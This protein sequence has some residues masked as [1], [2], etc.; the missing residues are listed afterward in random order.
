MEFEPRVL[1]AEPVTS[2]QS[3]G[4]A[5]GRRGLQAAL[6]GGPGPTIDAVAASGL[7]GRG[8]AGFP[9]ATKWRTVAANLSEELPASVVVNAAEGEP[10]SFKDRAILLANPYRVLEGALIAA[11]TI[12]ADEVVI[13]TKSRWTE[14][15]DRVRAAA[16][17]LNAASW[18]EGVTIDVVGGPEEYLFG[19]ETALLEVIEGR[20]PFPRL[21]PPWRR[22]IDDAVGDSALSGD[23]ELAVSDEETPVPPVLVNNVETMANLP[24]ILALGADWF[25]S[26]GTLKSPGTLVCTITGDTARHGVAEVPMGTPLRQ[27]IEEVGGGVLRGPEPSAVLS[28]VSNPLIPSTMLDT[29]LSYEAMAA[30]GSGLGTG[31]YIVFDQGTD[32]VAVA[33][34]VARFLSVESCGQCTP[35]KQDGV[36]ISGLLGKVLVNQATETDLDILDRKLDTVTTGA[37][38]FLATQQQLVVSSLLATFPDAMAAH[39]VGPGRGPVAEPRL[40][41]EIERLDPGERVVLDQRHAAKQ[42]DWTFDAEDS[43]EAPADRLDQRGGEA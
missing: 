20:M 33:A 42:P 17:E 6:D 21:A 39:A 29:P 26:V 30:A 28:G 41:A 15:I 11:V 9:T 31:G 38:C 4:D 32:P 16:A 43:G 8:G 2:L 14:V 18:A 24:A 12:G 3:W 13:A 35:C 40:I 36:V 7:R 5:G 34:G 19:E 27:V 22:G 25:R 10:G 1:D 23:E 37:R